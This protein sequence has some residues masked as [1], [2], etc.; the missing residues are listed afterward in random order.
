MRGAYYVLA[1]LLVVASSQIAAEFGHQLPVYDDGI[2]AARNAVVKTLPKRYLRGGHDVHDDSANEERSLYSVLVSL[3]NEGVMK[4]PRATEELNMM[5]R[6]AD[7]V[8]VMFRPAEVNEEMPH[9]TKE[10]L[11]KASKSAKEAL[12]KLWKPASRTAADG[13]ASHDIPTGE[14]LYLDLEAW[15][16]KEFHMRGG[17]V[18][19]KHRSMIASVHQEFLNLC[20]PNLH[21]TAA[22]TSLLWGMF[23]WKPELCTIEIHG[24]NLM[25]LAKRDVQKGVLKITSNELLDNQWNQLS[26]THK[27]SVQN[28]LLN[29]YYQR[30]VRMYNIFKRNRPDLIAAPLNLE[31]NLGT[32]S[33]LALRKHSQVPSN[34]ASTS[35]VKS[36]VITKRSKRTFDSNT[37]TISLSSKQAKMQS[38]KSVVPLLTGATTSGE[39]VVPMQNLKLSLGGPSGGF[40]PY[41]PPKAHSLKSLTPASTALTLE[42]S[43]TKLSLGGIYDKRTD[44][45]PSVP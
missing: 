39:H 35:N 15:D 43:E 37:G 10:E 45:A 25:R 4:L 34:A 38:S 23:H 9:I 6:A 7:D 17:S 44:K 3:I 2:M 40:A 28:C 36:S 19:K 22:E 11:K 5:P 30:W 29:L 8:E 27:L 14:K 18:I 21:P 1:A 32:S 13:H 20:D 33:A 12:K 26:D 16:I 31:L 41:E 24:R 42:D